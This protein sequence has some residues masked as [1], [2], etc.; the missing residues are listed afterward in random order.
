MR[1][2]E[3][4]A[5]CFRAIHTSSEGKCEVHILAPNQEKKHLWH[6]EHMKKVQEPIDAHMEC[7]VLK[8]NYTAIMSIN[9]HMN[10]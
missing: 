2:E 1:A 7:I 9:I 10:V 4:S 6:T 3:S 8:P 5:T